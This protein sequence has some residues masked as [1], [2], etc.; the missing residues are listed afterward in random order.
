[1][2]QLSFTSYMSLSITLTMTNCCFMFL[3]KSS[4]I[5]WKEIARTMEVG[6]PL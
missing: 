4:L 3:D 1:M 6:I 5:G 2:I